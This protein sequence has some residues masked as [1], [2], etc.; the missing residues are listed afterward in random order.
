MKM[1]NYGESTIKHG[2]RFSSL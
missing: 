1:V 2:I